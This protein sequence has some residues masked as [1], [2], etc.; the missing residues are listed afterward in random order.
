MNWGVHN[1]HI[2]VYFY[3]P[4]QYVKYCNGLCLWQVGMDSDK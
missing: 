2:A 1:F 4:F 3:N